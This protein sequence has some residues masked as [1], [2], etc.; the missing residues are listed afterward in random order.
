MTRTVKKVLRS[1]QGKFNFRPNNQGPVFNKPD[2][3][4]TKN[5]VGDVKTNVK[6]METL[7]C[8]VLGVKFD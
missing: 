1:V 7:Y 3:T 2:Q 4:E 8:K 6:E 5:D